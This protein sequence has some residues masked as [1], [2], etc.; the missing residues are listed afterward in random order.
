MYWNSQRM[1]RDV[2]LK[3]GIMGFHEEVTVLNGTT[4][5]KLSSPLQQ[6]IWSLKA[7]LVIKRNAVFREMS[8]CKLYP[9]LNRAKRDATVCLTVTNGF[10]SKR[11][12]LPTPA[13]CNLFCRLSNLWPPFYLLQ[14]IMGNDHELPTVLKCR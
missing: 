9:C 3:S 12:S 10:Q 6:G 13:V 2:S 11:Q 1:W 8:G 7:N 4:P 14:V 5:K